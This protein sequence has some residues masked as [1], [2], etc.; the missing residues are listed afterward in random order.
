MDIFLT[1][2]HKIVRHS[3][4]DFAQKQIVPIAK[5]IDEEQRFPWEV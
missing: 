3:V 5:E 4:Q 1:E 2:K